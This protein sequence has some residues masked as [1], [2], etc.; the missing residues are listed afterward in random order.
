MLLCL[1]RLSKPVADQA[2]Q[3]R[4]NPT[5]PWLP[6]RVKEY[7]VSA[8]FKETFM[9]ATNIDTAAAAAEEDYI[10]EWVIRQAK[11][12][13]KQAE[14]LLKWLILATDQQ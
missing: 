10:S 12:C 9:A 13:C 6:P 8:L 14:Q 1:N 3:I 7:L 11:K 2:D 4:Q 5:I